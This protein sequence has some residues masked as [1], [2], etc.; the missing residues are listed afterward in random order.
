MG[1]DEQIKS[2]IEK[3]K[4]QFLPESFFDPETR[5]SMYSLDEEYTKSGKNISLVSYLTVFIFSA[6]VAISA[7]LFTAKLQKEGKELKIDISSFE[8][9]KLV[10]VITET[11]KLQ[12]ALDKNRRDLLDLNMDFEMELDKIDQDYITLKDSYIAKD[13]PEDERDIKLKEIAAI[14]DA[15]I[16]KTKIKYQSK[17][18]KVN[19]DIKKIE[20]EIKANNDKLGSSSLK[21]ILGSSDQLNSIEMQRF[22]EFYEYKINKVTE[23]FKKERQDLVFSY[24]PIFTDSETKMMI[25]SLVKND[26]LPLTLLDGIEDNLVKENAAS[27][28]TI[29]K[30]REN[31][32]RDVHLLDKLQEVPYTNSIPRTLMHNKQATV[33][34]IKNYDGIVLSLVKTIDSKNEKM[35]SFVYSYDYLLKKETENGLILD[36]RNKKKMGL[37]LQ[38]TIPVNDGD[39]AFIFRNDQYV[40]ALK[41]SKTKNGIY[42]VLT[43]VAAGEI[44]L[45]FDKIMIKLK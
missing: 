14:R 3:S 37:Y 12:T 45:P 8:D 35:E 40:G 38:K 7:F 31:V 10:D 11:K 21:A 27:K 2:L 42:G 44:I 6:V 15:G 39:S 43:E 23:R 41:F 19:N 20:Q 22:R 28:Q 18:A 17:I 9:T 34:A 36:P 33:T 24:N 16:E 30:I 13:I 1:N 4:A 32:R 25:Y 26:K 5:D 29:A